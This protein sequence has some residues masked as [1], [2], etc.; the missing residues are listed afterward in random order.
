MSDENRTWD[1]Y[2][3]IAVLPQNHEGS[4]NLTLQKA[5]I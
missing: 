1:L 5:L 2:F 3:I 4:L